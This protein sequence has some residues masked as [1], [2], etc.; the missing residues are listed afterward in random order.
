[1]DSPPPRFVIPDACPRCGRRGLERYDFASG[2]D[3]AGSFSWCLARCT[4]CSAPLYR[5]TRENGGWW[6]QWDERR[7]H[8]RRAAIAAVAESLRQRWQG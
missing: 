8:N 2:E 5:H 4:T 6:D 1:M 7:W 3:R